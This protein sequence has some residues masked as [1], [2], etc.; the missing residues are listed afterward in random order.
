MHNDRGHMKC[1]DTFG[2]GGEDSTRPFVVADLADAAANLRYVAKDA[3]TAVA[4]MA[5]SHLSGRC[6][7]QGSMRSR[8]GAVESGKEIRR[9]GDDV[10]GDAVV[11]PTQVRWTSAREELIWYGHRGRYSGLL[12]RQGSW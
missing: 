8:F 3:P 5:V 12:A 7:G 6:D 11:E 10:V 2:F 4:E 1:T 9:I